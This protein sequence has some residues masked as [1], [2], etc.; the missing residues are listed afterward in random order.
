MSML[1]RK[2]ILTAILFIKLKLSYDEYLMKIC[3][4]KIENVEKAKMIENFSTT[5]DIAKF[6]L[7]FVETRNFFAFDLNMSEISRVILPSQIMY[8]KQI[9][10]GQILIRLKD[11]DVSLKLRKRMPMKLFNGKID[12]TKRSKYL[13]KYIE[14]I[15]CNLTLRKTLAE[16][17]GLK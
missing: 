4:G 3:R 10:R 5:E 7:A 1:L 6:K 15:K 14:Q 11:I 17:K 9:K 13:S 8:K 12:I 16:I 2:K